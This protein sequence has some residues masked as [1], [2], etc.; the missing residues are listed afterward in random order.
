[1]NVD[2]QI[3]SYVQRQREKQGVI[4]IPAKQGH[5]VM[6][7]T[8]SSTGFMEMI[9]RERKNDESRFDILTNLGEYVPLIMCSNVKVEP[10]V[11]IESFQTCMKMFDRGAS[12]PLIWN[13]VDRRRGVIEEM[14]R[15]F[16]DYDDKK[17]C[18]ETTSSYVL[19]SNCLFLAVRDTLSEST[20]ICVCA[21][22]KHEDFKFVMALRRH[23]KPIP[24]SLIT[25]FVDET[26]DAPNF[27]YPAVRDLYRKHLRPRLLDERVMFETVSPQFMST[28]MFNPEKKFASFAELKAEQSSVWKLLINS[29]V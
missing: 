20:R 28:M 13:T 6:A 11:I 18:Y 14:K 4:E 16:F 17:N 19:K 9:E 7:E 3:E 1:M 24:R 12:Y 21:A 25:I 29:R 5:M 10:A 26:F 8:F 2:E 22:I 15:H 27:P 23:N